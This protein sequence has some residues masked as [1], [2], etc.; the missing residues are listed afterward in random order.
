MALR[1]DRLVLTFLVS[2]I[3]SVTTLAHP[4]QES[5]ALPKNE[6]F[7]YPNT[8]EGLQGLIEDILRAAKSKDN[9]KLSELIHGL[10]MPENSKWF[11]EVFGPGF[12]ASLSASYGRLAPNLEQD[13]QVIFENDVQR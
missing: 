12:G 2:L 8:S 4:H 6:A 13:L 11:P 10:L 7:G 1:Y 9:A 3:V 5:P